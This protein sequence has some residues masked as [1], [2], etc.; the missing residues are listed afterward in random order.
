MTRWLA[1]LRLELAVWFG[2]PLAYFVLGGFCGVSALLFFDQ[3]RHYN[4][5]LFVYSSTALGGFE[6]HALPGALNL[7]DAVFLPLL[8]SLGLTLLAV[9]PLVAMRSFA[10]DRAAGRD[11]LLLVQGVGPSTVV[12]AK[13]AVC[14]ATLGSMLAL[15]FVYPAASVESGDLGARP[16]TSAFA[17][18][19]A[20]SAGLAGL[21]L[22]CSA[23]TRH[24]LVAAV[25]AWTLGVMLWDFGWAEPLVGETVARGL[26]ALAIRPRFLAL[27]RGPWAAADLAYFA[28]WLAVGAAVARSS[29][30]LR[31]V[32]A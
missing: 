7:W 6:S 4:Q 31:R 29:F 17:A 24:Q 2:S 19:L 1:L 32:S 22:A 26:A 30:D 12:A 20:L 16:L 11:E 28:G 23:L 10:A 18:L 13:F 15:A 14:L 9:V 27:A 3:L 5:L 8:E 25:A 21:A